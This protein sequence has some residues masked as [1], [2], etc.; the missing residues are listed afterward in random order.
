MVIMKCERC[1]HDIIRK[2]KSSLKEIKCS[3]CNKKYVLDSVTKTLSYIL[4][5]IL[6]FVLSYF[7]S[8]I[9]LTFDLSIWFFMLPLIILAWFIHDFV[10]FIMAKLNKLKYK[11]ID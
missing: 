10:L 2:K 6:I 7:I 3:H 5:I 11:A 4:V 8:Y 1:G 9:S